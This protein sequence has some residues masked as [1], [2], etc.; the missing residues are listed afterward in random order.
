MG[1]DPNM[2]LE[3]GCNCSFH[4]LQGALQFPP[5]PTTRAAGKAYLEKGPQHL[6]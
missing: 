6:Q 1:P 5:I 2:K 3:V 4:T